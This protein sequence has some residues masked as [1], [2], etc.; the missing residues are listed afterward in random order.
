MFVDVCS[1]QLYLHNDGL[2]DGGMEVCLPFQCVFFWKKSEV[3][4][5][6]TSEDTSRQV[7]EDTHNTAGAQINKKTAEL[8]L[9]VFGVWNY[10]LS[11]APK[12]IGFFS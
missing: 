11:H 9:V 8:L 10:V 1:F 7:Q 5:I 2:A 4:V 12:K 6:V 3:V